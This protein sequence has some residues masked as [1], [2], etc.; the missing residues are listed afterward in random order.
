MDRKSIE[1]GSRYF[2]GSVPE[3]ALVDGKYK[4]EWVNL[5][6][7]KNG[8]YE[9]KDPNDVALLRFDISFNGEVV[10]DGSY[11]TL[12]PVDTTETVLRKALERIMDAVKD[13]CNDGDCPKKVFEELS[14]IEPKWFQG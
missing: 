10:P 1:N 12:M 11:C 13:K 5:G 8:E 7:G 2:E 6:E 9:S 4:V 3:I 14:W